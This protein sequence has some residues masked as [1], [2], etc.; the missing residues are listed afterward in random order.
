MNARQLQSLRSSLPVFGNS[1]ADVSLLR[2]YCVAYGIDFDGHH[3]AVQYTVGTVHSG[4]Y[5]LAV[6]HW[7]RDGAVSN[8][9]LLHGYFD[10]TGLYGELIDWALR[11][12]CNVLSFDLPGHGLSSGEPAAISHFGEYSQAITDTLSLGLQGDLPQWVIAQSTG[13]A[14]LIDF[15]RTAA[16]WPFSASVLLAPLVRPVSWS[17]VRLTQ[18]L[19]NRF[20]QRVPRVFTR[21][22]TDSEFLAR[23][24]ADPLQSQSVSV[25]WVGALRRWLDELTIADLGR[26]PALVVQ[27][28]ADKTVDWPYNLGVVEQLFPGSQIQMLAG[29]RHH[30]AGE[31]EAIRSI[32]LAAVNDWLLAHG[33]PLLNAQ[34]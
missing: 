20:L 13:A 5:Q 31:S 19:L 10:H 15:G 22:S 18:I 1:I 4:E 14:A 17:R 16:A 25:R 12:G 23:L 6:H 24:R 29:A 28:D 8:L 9:L 3:D 7:Q 32:Y 11:R 26:G 33:V 30:L 34:Q 21:N 2:D 27:G